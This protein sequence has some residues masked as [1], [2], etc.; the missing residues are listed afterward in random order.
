MQTSPSPGQSLQAQR[1]PTGRR[2]PWQAD[3]R[4]E[5]TELSATQRRAVVAVVVGLHLA[6]VWALLQLHAV[7]EAAEQIS[8]MLVSWLPTPAPPEPEPTKSEPP[9]VVPKPKVTPAAPAPVVTSTAPPTPDAIVAPPPPEVMPAPAPPT[10]EVAPSAPVA[11][12]PAPKLLPD[13]AVKYLE[14]PRVEYPRLSQRAAEVG[15]VVVRAYIGA[16]GGLPHSVQVER[17]S[18]YARLDQ[19]AVSAVKKARF[20][21]YAEQG[22]PVEGWALIPIRF[23][24]EK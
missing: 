19:A 20:M 1:S 3:P 8:P 18:G 24:L 5:N 11:E 4:T 9:K 16:S 22:Q 21:P 12:A 15:L 6:T 10:I 23:E 2:G 13:S 14:E 7:R 17:S